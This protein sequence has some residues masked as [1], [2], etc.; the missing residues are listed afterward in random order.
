MSKKKYD[1]YSDNDYNAPGYHDEA[2]KAKRVNP[3]KAA[4]RQEL[5][6][7][8]RIRKKVAVK[9]TKRYY[10]ELALAGTHRRPEMGDGRLPEDIR[11]AKGK[12]Y[13]YVMRKFVCLLIC[14]F[15]LAGIAL[16][17]VGYLNLL[18]EYTSFMTAPDYTPENERTG[19]I[20]EETDTESPYVDKSVYY[21][22]LDPIAGFLNKLT[23]IDL[24][25]KFP[26][27]TRMNANVEIGYANA[28]AG[29]IVQFFPIAMVLYIIIALINFI[30]A[31]LAIFGKRIFKGFGISAILMIICAGVMLLAGVFTNMG[32]QS[33][34]LDFGGLMPF[35]M[36]ALS[37]PEDPATAPVIAS[38][39]GLLGM[40]V[41]P[42]LILLLSFLAKK[43]IPFSIFD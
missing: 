25:I 3:K 4:I 10:R 22:S 18:P 20:D 8:Q 41:I 34:A 40:L 32:P 6:K 33:E 9:N 11:T 13:F 42:V 38:G 30:K 19:V 28:I 17:V 2:P 1:E 39:F 15:F 16:Y 24:G 35:I 26:L 12:D 43:R 31:I 23:N 36:A 14:V 37:A 27:F 7:E 29:Y 21:T 5:E